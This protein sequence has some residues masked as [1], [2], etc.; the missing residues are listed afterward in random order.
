MPATVVASEMTSY[1][2]STPKFSADGTTRVRLNVIES[3]A[4]LEAPVI[5]KTRVW[6]PNVELSVEAKKYSL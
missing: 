2:A 1:S 5:W 4:S 3:V 6:L